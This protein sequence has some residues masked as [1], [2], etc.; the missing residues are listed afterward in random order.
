VFF[1]LVVKGKA[2]HVMTRNQAVFP[3]AHN[4]GSGHEVG[5]DALE[6][7]LPF[8]EMLYR[9]ERDWNLN[10]RGE[11]LGSGGSPYHDCMGVGIFVIN[12]C[13][14]E[15]KS[16]MASLLSEIKI[17]YCVYFNNA[18]SIEDIKN[19]ISRDVAA[20]ASTDSWLRENPPEVHCP[21]L[22]QWQGLKTD[23]NDPGIAVLKQAAKDAL[24]REPTVTGLKTVCDASYFEQAGIPC[25]VLGPGT[26]DNRL[27]GTDEY[28]D[29]SDIIEATK[30][31]ASMMIDYCC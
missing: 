21:V 30:V 17:T 23:V 1:D 19:E 31:Y 20:L 29:I 7:A 8:I 27:H 15:V 28:M 9:K 14:I 12:P 10:F 3:Q 6:K 25:V 18:Y 5:V 11:I 13:H 2:N 22:Y 26:P 24:G 16:Y 4:I